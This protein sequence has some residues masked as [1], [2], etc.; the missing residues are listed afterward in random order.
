MKIAVL[1][2]LKFPIR[3]PFAGGLE[4]HTHLMSRLLRDRGHAVTLFA[5]EGSDLGLG[6]V[7]VCPPTGI[8]RGDAIGDA[9]IDEAEF[10]AYAAIMEAVAEGGFDI[11]H[12]NS[13]HGLPLRL[14]GALATPMLT[15]LHTPPFE[16]FVDGVR[17][18]GPKTAFAA[19]SPSLAAQW[20]SLVLAPAIVGNGI[21]LAVF[22]FRPDSGSAPFAFWSGRIV[23]EKGLHLAID[24][25]RLAGLPLSFAGPRYDRDYW[26]AE[27]APRLGPDLTDHGHL[28]QAKL[29]EKLGAA[30]VAV[31][32]PCWEEPF[33]LVVA[34]ALACG[35][36]VAGFRRGSLPDILDETCGRLARPGDVAD[37]AGAMVEAA[38]L[39]RQ[40]C[41]RR[42]EALFDATTMID[43]YEALYRD[44][45]RGPKVPKSRA[46]API[47]PRPVEGLT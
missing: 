14:S 42:A 20:R 11:I 33:G 22:P 15:V 41:R 7:A 5:A 6:T 18:A 28:G 36:P 13:L 35:T 37:L 17:A 39:A 43:R 9:Q 25:A 26:E 16:P 23:P 12:N 29:A 44:L 31:A 1:A 2:H 3:Q 4:L 19:V 38:G 45:L 10:V 27:I 21:D 34:E 40:A 24:A 32:S 8:A 30:R 47:D 46:A